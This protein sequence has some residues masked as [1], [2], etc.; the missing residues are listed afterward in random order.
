MKR[1]NSCRGRNSV[2]KTPATVTEKGQRH[3]SVHTSL[4]HSS[5]CETMSP[6]KRVRNDHHFQVSHLASTTDDSAWIYTHHHQL[7][8]CPWDLMEMRV[9]M[10]FF[11]FLSSSFFLSFSFS[12]SFFFPFSHCSGPLP[13]VFI[14]SNKPSSG[15]FYLLQRNI[16][17]L[18]TMCPAVEGWLRIPVHDREDRIVACKWAQRISICLVKKLFSIQKEMARETESQPWR[19]RSCLALTVNILLTVD[20]CEHK[21]NSSHDLRVRAWAQASTMEYSACYQ[22]AAG[23][24]LS[25]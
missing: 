18:S 7:G 25:M 23:L 17:N 24:T 20:M 4:M 2:F 13:K 3:L 19:I 5:L 10:S 22:S 15:H 21:H 12:L 9:A 16:L 6:D 1:S 8:L 14:D 11:C